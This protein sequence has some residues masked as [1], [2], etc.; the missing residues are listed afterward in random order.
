MYNLF[1]FVIYSVLGFILEKILSLFNGGITDSGFMYGPYT[2]VYGI[3]LVLL[4]LL[5]DK[6]K[7][8]K[9][10]FKRYFY[11][12]I[13]AFI[14]LLILEF[15]AGVLLKEILNRTMWDYTNMPLNIGKYISIEITTIWTTL[16]L[17]VY[18]FVKPYTDILYKKTNKY[19]IIGFSILMLCDLI[20]TLFLHFFKV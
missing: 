11:M 12:F 15:S 20:I 9:P 1:N 6:Y 10:T 4:F 14:I 18:K 17:L 8:I 5:F 16:V 3:G 19:Y 7:S 13:S 2:I